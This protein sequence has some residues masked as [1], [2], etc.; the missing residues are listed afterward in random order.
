[1]VETEGVHFDEHFA[2]GGCGF[3]DGLDFEDGGAAECGDFDGLHNFLVRRCVFC[4]KGFEM[5]NV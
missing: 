1:M 2:M 5:E 3:G 4:V